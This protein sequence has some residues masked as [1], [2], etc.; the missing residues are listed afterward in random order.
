MERGAGQGKLLSY[1]VW[2]SQQLEI[3]TRIRIWF[4]KIRRSITAAKES[5]SCI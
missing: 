4:W 5:R 3:L 2:R 1:L